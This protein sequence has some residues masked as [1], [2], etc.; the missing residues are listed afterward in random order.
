M[1]RKIYNKT[2]NK[3]YNQTYN[4]IYKMKILKIIYMTNSTKHL[5]L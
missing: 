3:T 1:I 2:Y 5:K 4:K